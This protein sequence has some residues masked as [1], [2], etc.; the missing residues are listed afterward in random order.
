MPSLFEGRAAIG[1][2][3]VHLVKI[4]G[5]DLQPA[6]AVFAFTANG[7]GAE[8][9]GDFPFFIPAQN[10]LCEDMGARATPFPQC[11]GNDFFRMAQAVDGGGV[12]PI[13]AKLKRAMNRGNGVRI[14]LVAPGKFP[15]GTANGPRSKTDG[16]DLEVR[17][18][19]LARFHSCFSRKRCGDD[20]CDRGT[21]SNSSCLTDWMCQSKAG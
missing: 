9:L 13:D 17:V 16:R 12:D 1:R 4:D 15:A 3:P 6:K 2:R 19:E 14:I 8:S 18:S 11:A 10:T 20:V 7:I 5:F 21:H